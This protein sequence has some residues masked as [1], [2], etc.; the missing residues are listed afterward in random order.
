MMNLP[1]RLKSLTDYKLRNK[2]SN[3]YKVIAAVGEGSSDIIGFCEIENRSVIEML[4]IQTPLRYQVMKLS[5]KI[6][7]TDEELMLDL[8]T[9]RQILAP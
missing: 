7:G 6:Q 2:I 9:E 8:Y 1:K 4:I 5:I 3:I